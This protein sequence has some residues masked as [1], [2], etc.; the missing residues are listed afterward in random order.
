MSQTAI[1]KA[2]EQLKAE[3]AANGSVLVIDEFVFA[4]IPGLDI[5][6]PINRDESWPAN[7]QIVHRQDVSKTGM[8]NDN[9]VVYSVTLGADVGDFEFNWI[10]LAS[11]TAGVVCMIVHAP[12]QKKIKNASG[13]QGNVLSRSF[14]MEY[15]GAAE[16]T[17]ILT[18]VDTWQIDFTSR[19]N[20]TDERTRTEN[21]DVWGQAAFIGDGLLVS[22]TGNQYNVSKGVGYIAGLRAELLASQSVTVTSKPMKI[23]A[24]V[25]WEGTLTSEWK[26]ICKITAAASLNDY[27]DGNQKH[28][29]FALAEVLADGS[30]K[31]LRPVGRDR[32]AKNVFEDGFTLESSS[33]LALHRATGKFYLWDGSVPKKVPAGSTPAT[34]GGTGTGA[35]IDVAGGVESLFAEASGDDSFEKS[36]FNLSTSAY[37]VKNKRL[38]GVANNKLRTAKP[39]KI[40]FPGD[41]ITYGYDITSADKL[42]ALPGHTTTRAPVQYPARVYE[43]L[44]FF[45]DAPVTAINRGFSGDTARKC[46]ERWPDNPG[47]DVAHIMLGINDAAGRYEATFE[48]YCEYIEKLI[49]QYIDWGHGVVIHTSTAQTF[50]NQ[51]YGGARFSQYARSVAAVYGCPVFESEGV[52]QYCRFAEVYSDAT[53]FNKAGYAKYGD[54]VTAFI[55]AGGWVR[56]V[57]PIN[58]PT[59]Q[60]PGRAT[61][62]IGWSGSKGAALGTSESSSYTWNG[63]TGTLN[64]NTEGVHSFSFF[65]D[66][67]AANVYAVARLNGAKI[68][69]SD[70]LTTVDGHEAVNMMP[71]KFMPRIIAETKSYKV[72]T[73]PAGYKVW[74][75]ALVGRGWKTV[76]VQ[77]DPA[78][79]AAVYLNELMIEP[80]IPEMVVQK[81]DAALPGVKEVIIYNHPVAAID[82]P[83]NIVPAKAPM[84][85]KVY[86]P[87][88][89]GLY[90]QSQLWGHWYDNLKV[91]LTI[92]TRYSEGGDTYNGVHKLTAYTTTSSAG[93]NLGVIETTFK[94]QPNCIKPVSINYGWADPATPDV[95]TEGQYPE[96]LPRVSVMYLVINFPDSPAAYNSVEVECNAIM[97]GNG[98]YMY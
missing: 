35:W 90:R 52:H 21:I 61:E 73:R 12:L 64:A 86:L 66:S 15:D 69:L 92:L 74:L 71:P 80:C 72:S 87:L 27:F 33:L 41:S 89:K 49:R 10:G 76:Y 98:T 79:D 9:A 65:L 14:M 81:N 43:K 22:K 47:C 4:N 31:D 18:P 75:G 84:P 11:K 36:L 38:L 91:D 82:N 6:E 28:Y 2:F 96:N 30:V 60:Q 57:R 55:L 62:G 70:P 97:N 32:L 50:N 48:E 37:A 5:N 44:S 67:E 29:V 78:N 13:Q 68:S 88:P 58:S 59:M 23:Y 95:I 77:Q 93:A 16:Q 56:P 40:V 8:V 3:Q 25:S 45:T 1:T 63:Q 39:V 85:R 42:D 46:F 20:G 26:T 54:A 19:L 51:N 7:N 17:Q 53:H 24:D 34:A 94:S 83:Q